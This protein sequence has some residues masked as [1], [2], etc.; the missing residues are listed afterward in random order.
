M[1]SVM[2]KKSVGDLID[3][4][5]LA[6]IQGHT[7]QIPHPAQLTHLQFRRFAGCPMCNLHIQSFI[8][9]HDVLVTHGI[10]EVDVFHSSQKSMLLHHA[11]A[12]FALI[13]DPTKILYRQFGVE[14]SLLSV[15]NPRSWP[16][17]VKGLF[18]HGMGLP[19]MGESI[20]GLPA[21][22]LIDQQG[23]IRAIKYGV[24]AYDQWELDELLDIVKQVRVS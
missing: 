11:D 6:S 12:P 18:R 10:Q 7:V 21:D 3:A 8:A 20:T 19:E 15:L 4:F 13:A 24:H 9:R 14:S 16:A 2:S 23:R 1:L 17:A 22:V 5:P